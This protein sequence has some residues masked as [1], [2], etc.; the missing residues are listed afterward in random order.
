MR[1]LFYPGELT[2]EIRITG[3]DA[4]H[5]ARVMRAQLGDVHVV[6]GADGRAA[7]M[8]VTAV[9]RD[10]VTLRLDSYVEDDAPAR[11]E[12]ILVQAL[13]KGEKTDFVVQKAVELGSTRS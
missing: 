8:T 11:A 12:V 5:L 1:R 10:A 13:L 6:A 7:R 3:G 2:P 9:A 4:Y